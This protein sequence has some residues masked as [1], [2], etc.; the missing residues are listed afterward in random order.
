MT[1]LRSLLLT[2][3]LLP[4]SSF[5]AV[6]ATLTVTPTYPAPYQKVTVSLSSYSFDVN[7]AII[8]WQSGNKVLDS[9]MGKKALTLTLGDAGQV[10]PLT[11]KAVTADGTTVAGSISIAP[12]AVDLAY[13]SVESYTPA[14]YEGKAL[15]GEGSLIKIVALPIIFESG[16]RLSPTSLSYSWYVNGEFK[17]S[18]SGAGKQSFLD[19]LD[20]LTDSTTVK[21]LVRSPRGNTAEK[22]ITI[23]PAPVLP[24]LYQ[25]DEVL[26]TLHTKPFVRRMELSKDITL[27][28][29]PFYLSTKRSL[30]AS[31]LFGWY[32]DG[33]P[34]TPE[35]KTM[36]SLRPTK[37]AVGSRK[38]SIV[39]ENSKRILQ[40]ARTDIE[41]IFDTR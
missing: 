28:L 2:T 4:F 21:V 13:E 5:A 30:D 32:I 15:P 11:Y 31:A 38:L 10:L 17:E 7:T 20:Y 3:L 6:D 24:I 8:T 27:V 18:A 14:F 34:V 19:S 16:S 33:L 25:Y 35:E 29:E 37:D 1:F 39:V 36:L 41:I 12:Q 22:S 23:Y 26:G 9:G 40:K